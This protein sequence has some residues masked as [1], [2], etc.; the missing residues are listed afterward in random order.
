[1]KP[2]KYPVEW[3]TADDVPQRAAQEKVVPFDPE[4]R[5]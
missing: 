3:P 5:P 1:M 4:K 2:P